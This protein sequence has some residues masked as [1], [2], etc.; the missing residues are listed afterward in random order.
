MVKFRYYK[1]VNINYIEDYSLKILFRYL[2]IDNID[3]LL[4]GLLLEWRI[5]IYS[6]E[7]WVLNYILDALT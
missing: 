1:Y 7:I 4:W 2:S 3:I 5:F 6:S